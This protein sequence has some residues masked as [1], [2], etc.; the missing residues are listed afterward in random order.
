MFGKQLESRLAGAALLLAA[1]PACA[2][3]IDIAPG[4]EQRALRREAARQGIRAGSFVIEPQV[5]ALV[6][7]DD[8]VYARDDNR[9]GDALIT[10]E[11]RL[12]AN[13]DFGAHALSGEA[14]ARR[15]QFLSIDSEN[16]D[17][18]GAGLGA[19]LDISR[20]T[21]VSLRGRYEHLAER[22]GSIDSL[23]GSQRPAQFDNFEGE[24]AAS[25]RFNRLRIAASARLRRLDYAPVPIVGVETDQ[26]FRDF[27]VASGTL[28]ADYELSGATA[29]VLRGEA[30]RRRYDLRTG[31]PGFDPVTSLDRSAEGVRIEAGIA[32]AFNNVI[33]GTIRVGYLRYTY[34]D[35]NI[36][37]V[38]GL[39][40]SADVHW[41]VTRLTTLSFSALRQLDE[42][43]S[44]LTSGSLRDEFEVAAEHELLRTLIVNLGA[45]YSAIAISGALS[46]SREFQAE[47]GA[48]WFPSRNIAL[49]MQLLHRQRNSETAALDFSLNQI[50]FGIT[51]RR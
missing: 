42:T 51:L 13:S 8:N 27:N 28:T 23:L 4:V 3:Q 25:H 48:R 20:R 29:L 10:A 44:P 31:D 43:L 41:D 17:E 7:Y 32:R 16:V 30:E 15:R 9:R 21:N 33:S 18:Y 35:P 34:P 5:Q 6:T 36:P 47:F 50:T 14:F 19:R 11:A 45:R 38:S 40:Y 1:A 2:Q 49:Q 39:S 26:D 24:L 22:R 46:D 37:A 12:R